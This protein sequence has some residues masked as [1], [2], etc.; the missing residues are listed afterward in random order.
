M[1]LHVLELNQPPVASALAR[2][3]ADRPGT[4]CGASRQKEHAK[5]PNL[6]RGWAV[7]GWL[8]RGVQA[9]VGVVRSAS[10]NWSSSA[11]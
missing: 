8:D 4:W 3:I 6:S 9:Q 11:G 2:K 1:A 10:P 7:G 5:R